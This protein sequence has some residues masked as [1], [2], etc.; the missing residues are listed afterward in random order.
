MVRIAKA[1]IPEDAP[2]H[3]NL[4]RATL[5]NPELHRGFVGLAGRVHSASH[6]SPR[7][8]EIVVLPTVAR[9]RSAYEWGNHVAGARSVGLTDDEI[10]RLRDGPF[11]D[12]TASEQVALRYATAVEDRAVDDELWT[13]AREHF[14]EVE[15]LDMTLLVAFYGMA[16]RFVLALEVDLDDGL[17]G[18]DQP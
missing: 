11:D 12:F 5:N 8:R 1:K 2:V 18:L 6:L 13:L 15:L 9:L 4:V 14:S 7:L 17:S 10:V 16:S 3:N